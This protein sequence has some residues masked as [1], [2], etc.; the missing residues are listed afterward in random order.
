MSA[1]GQVRQITYEGRSEGETATDAGWQL[2]D[3]VYQQVRAQASHDEA[4]QVTIG[5]MSFGIGALVA[6][7]GLTDASSIVLKILAGCG[8]VDQAVAITAQT[9]RKAAG[10]G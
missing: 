7:F 10:H 3:G 9:L 4:L 1:E 6:H 5:A 8:P 2:M